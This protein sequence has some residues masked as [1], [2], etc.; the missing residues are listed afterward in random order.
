MAMTSDPTLDDPGEESGSDLAG[1][2]G[3]E[4]SLSDDAIASRVNGRAANASKAVDAARERAYDRDLIARAAK[5][6]QRAFRELVQRHQRRA[7]VVAFGIVRNSE[8]AR[9]VVQDAFVR[10]WKHLNDFAGQASFSTWLYRIVYNLS[11]DALRRRSPGKAIELD[12]RTDLEGAP[13][14]LLPFRGVG[15]PFA[16]V[17][18]GRLV[19]AMQEALDALPAYHRMVIV[20]R[21]VEGLS[22]EE[23]A[24][25]TNVPK[26]TVMSRLFH[27]RRKM[28]SLLA[29]R[30]GTEVPLPKDLREG[31][32]G[33]DP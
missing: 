1:I 26:G 3:S 13:E 23:I 25:S 9:E 28:Q 20:L 15:D 29:E 7:S 17:D 30:L 27:A 24:E 5:G 14:E 33:S 16:A 18:R 32:G 19:D 11:I 6:D 12:E 2:R 31:D 4:D 22:Y 8:D 21:E 10:V